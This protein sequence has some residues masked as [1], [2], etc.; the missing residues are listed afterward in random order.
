MAARNILH[1][2]KLQEFKDWLDKCGIEHRPGRGHWE[3]LQVRSK[4]GTKWNVIYARGDTDPNM[5]ADHL[6]VTKHL[7]P[8][9]TRYLGE[10]KCNQKPSQNSNFLESK[11]V[12]HALE[13]DASVPWFTPE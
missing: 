8:L 5:M 7:V 9:V 10:K 6:S 4:C 13:T 12:Q 1:K 2:D 11:K 3:M